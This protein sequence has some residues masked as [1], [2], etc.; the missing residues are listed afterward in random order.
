MR[1]TFETCFS[2]IGEFGGHSSSRD[3]MRATVIPAVDLE[4]PS[5]SHCTNT[6][7]AMRR[8]HERF[9]D[10]AAL[11]ARME[12]TR[13]QNQRAGGAGAMPP[14]T[15]PESLTMNVVHD[16]MML[17]I[18]KSRRNLQKDGLKDTERAANS[19]ISRSY[20]PGLAESPP[21]SFPLESIYFDREVQDMPSYDQQM[22]AEHG[23]PPPRA[24]SSP[25]AEWVDAPSEP[26]PTPDDDDDDEDDEDMVVRLRPRSRN[27]TEPLSRN[28]D[29]APA[30]Q[31]GS[32]GP[33]R[34]RLVRAA[35]GSSDSD[36]SITPERSRPLHRPLRVSESGGRSSRPA[37]S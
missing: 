15:G 37:R 7:E 24:D 31:Q 21:E 1:A 28:N 33:S 20:A 32:A 35:D 23:P 6:V 5:T 34:R 19:K 2:L 3:L 13:L 9:R 16:T 18:P 14:V 11:A 17:S 4:V 10:A 30:P 29:D 36:S 27:T 12:Q 26:A 25:R 22:A 8:N